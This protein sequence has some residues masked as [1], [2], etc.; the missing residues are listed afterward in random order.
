MSEHEWRP[1]CPPSDT[2]VYEDPDRPCTCERRDLTSALGF[3]VHV[4]IG[5]DASGR[6]DEAT[7]EFPTWEEAVEAAAGIPA[8][9]GTG[10]QVVS[11]YRTENQPRMLLGAE[12]AAGGAS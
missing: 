9:L 11:L 3:T 10:W 6:T 5:V 4:F 1:G 2:T 8:A 12:P 7:R